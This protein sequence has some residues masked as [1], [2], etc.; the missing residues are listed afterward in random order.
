MQW[1]LRWHNIQLLKCEILSQ[2]MLL[3]NMDVVVEWQRWI[4]QYFY[5]SIHPSIHPSILPSILPS[6]HPSVRRMDQQLMLSL[7]APIMSVLLIFW[8]VVGSCLSLW[9][10][11]CSYDDDGV[12]NLFPP[13]H[14]R[15]HH[16][17]HCHHHN[18]GIFFNV[19]PIYQTCFSIIWLICKLIARK[20]WWCWW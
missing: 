20:W 7:I 13:F 1:C 8:L 18:Y 14:H 16:H 10:W 19:K 15:H 11:W 12:S 5:P 2:Y 6:I 4:L 9:W 3:S 17:Q